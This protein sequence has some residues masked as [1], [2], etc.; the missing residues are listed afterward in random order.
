MDTTRPEIYSILPCPKGCS[1]SGFCLDTTKP[2]NVTS[3]LPA[4]ER[5][6]NASAR[7]DTEDAKKLNNILNPNN[8]TL[9]IIPNMA[10]IFL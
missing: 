10:Q 2:N 6:F 4:S 7:I 9:S 8:K 5:L 1:L 3:E